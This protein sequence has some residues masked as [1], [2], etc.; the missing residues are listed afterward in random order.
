M[1]GGTPYIE[2][3]KGWFKRAT[4]PGLV[5]VRPLIDFSLI[6]DMADQARIKAQVATAVPVGSI[7][8]SKISGSINGVG[9]DALYDVT[10]TSDY[11]AKIILADRN[12][13]RVT[14]FV[15]GQ[16]RRMHDQP[17][18]C[19]DMDITAAGILDTVTG[20]WVRTTPDETPSVSSALK[21]LQR[22][23][24]KSRAKI[25]AR[26]AEAAAAAATAAQDSE[27]GAL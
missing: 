24:L 11:F 23:R 20:T 18:E 9:A 3:E 22:R 25:A 8:L 2:F 16:L 19:F 7:A 14:L 4:F 27:G 5:H 26:A 1:K 12:R 13:Y 10:L 15:G 17:P 6:K 21:D